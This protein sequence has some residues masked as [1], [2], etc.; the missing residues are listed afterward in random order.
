MAEPLGVPFYSFV[1]KHERKESKTDTNALNDPGKLTDQQKLMNVTQSIDSI[2]YAQ[3]DNASYKTGKE[4][5]SYDEDLPDLKS[6]NTD[7]ERE[8]PITDSEQFV[9]S[10]QQSNELDQDQV[11]PVASSSG[12]LE[13]LPNHSPFVYDEDTM[14]SQCGICHDASY[15]KIFSTSLLQHNYFN[16]SNT[17]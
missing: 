1:E 7:P 11:V 6:S 9:C 3:S 2:F 4:Q 12:A 5:A 17:Y 10:L 15:N 13:S 14:V 8:L 16:R